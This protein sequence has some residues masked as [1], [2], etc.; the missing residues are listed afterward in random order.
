VE[1]LETAAFWDA[2]GRS[3]RSSGDTDAADLLLFVHGFNTTFEKAAR[4]TAQMAVDMSFPGTAAFF[5][6]P[7]DG[8]MA[9]YVA[10]REDAEWSA[11]DLAAFLETLEARPR[12]GRLHVIAHSMGNQVLVRA[13][14]DVSRR[15]PPGSEPLLDNVILAAPDVDADLFTA[16]LAPQ[17]L[18]L[19]RRFTLYVSDKDVALD[20]SAILGVRRLGMPLPLVEGM[21]T[22]D[23]TGVEVTPW[24]PPEFHDYYAT[25]LKVLA[26]LRAVLAGTPP[27][28]R[29][30]DVRRDHRR[31]RSGGGRGRVGDPQAVLPRC[32][33]PA[34]GDEDA[35]RGGP[36]QAHPGPPGPL[37]AVLGGFA[38]P[39]PHVFLPGCWFL[40]FG[41]WGGGVSRRRW[42]WR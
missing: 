7:S 33:D 35:R 3:L 9:R 1:P 17:I 21:E 18:H 14:L 42:R 25:K 6:W 29:A 2:V 8:S 31:A 30:L 27:G 4:R 32:F 41:V 19:A 34:R 36:R 38:G 40:P 5:S 22:V 28:K 13:L 26:D 12:S 23:A 15:R 11:Y 16:R 10:D 20:A 39:G 37:P 24:S